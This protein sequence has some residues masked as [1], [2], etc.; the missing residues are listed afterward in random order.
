M[1]IEIYKASEKDLDF[2]SN[3]MFEQSRYEKNSGFF[4]KLFDTNDNKIILDKLK[5]LMTTSSKSYLHLK[6]FLVAKVAGK[7]AGILCGYE[8]RID[9]Q[10]KFTSSLEE[11]GVDQSYKDRLNSFYMCRSDLD[12][13]TWV[14]DFIIEDKQFDA[15]DIYKAL[16]QKS[17]LTAR[18]KGYR[19]SQTMLDIGSVE[20]ELIYKKLGFAFI[21]ESI[22]QEYELDFNTSGVKRLEIQL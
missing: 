4:D 13:K 16:V 22:C 20:S 9:T 14:L 2:I 19:K 10:E 21:D 11:I 7:N 5:K 18:V 12:R 1:N 15:L 17:L 3:T 8:P 6:N